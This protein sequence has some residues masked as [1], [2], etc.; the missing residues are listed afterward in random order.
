MPY[1]FGICCLFGLLE[2]LLLLWLNLREGMVLWFI[3][4]ATIIGFFYTINLASLLALMGDITPLALSST[5]YQM[6]MSFVWIGNIPVSLVVGYLLT[7]DLS[8]CLGLMIF[9]TLSMA[10]V[11]RWIKPFEVAK[12][13]ST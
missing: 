11:S 3:V 2:V 9:F 7:I 13:T 12:A 4:S 5:V 6:Y 10:V 1:P 8:L